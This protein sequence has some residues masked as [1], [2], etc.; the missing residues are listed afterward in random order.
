MMGRQEYTPLP[1][2]LSYAYDK[3]NLSDIVRKADNEKQMGY[4]FT[5]DAF[6]KRT[7]VYWSGKTDA[8]QLLQSTTYHPWL[9]VPST[10]TYGNGDTVG[11]YYNRAGLMTDRL[12]N[13]KRVAQYEYNAHNALGSESYYR[14]YANQYEKKIYTYD[15]AGRMSRLE[16]ST[17]YG[18]GN[19]VYDKNNNLTN[20]MSEVKDG[21]LKLAYMTKLTYNNMNALTSLQVQPE[22]GYE[23]GT[24]R[25]G[26][27]GLGRMNIKKVTLDSADNTLQ[28][29]YT[30]KAWTD[31]DGTG[32]RTLRP[33]TT[34][35]SGTLGNSS[36]NT[37]YFTVFLGDGNIKYQR[38]TENGA[39]RKTSFAYDDLGQLTRAQTNSEA[40][41]TY[42]YDG[43]GNL[44]SSSLDG[45]YTSS[46]SYDENFSDLLTGYTKTLSDGTVQSRAYTYTAANGNTFVNPT[47][48]QKSTNGAPTDTLQLSWR[49]GRVLSS[50]HQ[51]A[52]QIRYEYNGDGLRTYREGTDGSRWYYYY[53]GSQ[54]EYVKLT[55]SSGNVTGV[56]RYIYNS[57]GQ[58]EY[59]MYIKSSSIANP[60][61]YDLYYILRDNLG[62]ITKLIKTRKAT[63]SSVTATLEIAAEYTYDPY[64]TVLNI[65][66]VNGD[67][68]A[69]LNQLMY[70]DYIY[71]SDTGWYYLQSRYYDPEVGRFINGD[72][73]V[74]DDILG[75]NSFA[76][77]GNNPINRADSNGESWWIVA[78]AVVGAL[79]GGIT[80][81][82]SNVITGKKW[83]DG[84][85]GAAVGG[86]VY[87]IVLATTGNVWAAGFA[88]AAAESWTNEALSYIPG[89]AQING[90]TVTKKLTKGNVINSAK[91]IIKDTAVN[92]TISA[93][94]GKLAGYIV[95]TGKTWIKPQKFVSSFF[96]KYAVKSELQTVTQSLGV[97]AA[98][99]AKQ[100]FIQ[101]SRLGQRPV[102]K[103]FPD[104]EIRAAG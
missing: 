95:P 44:T 31:T 84:L 70:K 41:Y 73:Q 28:T 100:V 18:V 6:G 12:Y 86:A 72:G 35:I 37:S 2:R 26:Y 30:Y 13:G 97:F 76:Y 22:G 60:K 53:N 90:Q 43:G 40:A 10:V 77:C 21:Q 69:S 89:V 67:A 61:T 71:D 94:T 55:D 4:H 20:Y 93:A 75:S 85:L 29:T 36:V 7:G 27:D 82:A 38:V 87:G 79:A 45:A 103:F 51:N 11:Y 57:S 92:G 102:I 1:T 83:Y 104:T 15:L 56:L 80:K 64:G 50:V 91:T 46:Y 65:R 3:G 19:I 33:S 5:Y 78:N 99:K 8:E 58:A 39:E 63:S 54:L 68:I 101:D 47:T 23:S 98:E 34:T 14:P 62:S 42:A 17:G 96:G 52:G 88:G 32:L 24:I 25:Y 59:V 49:E 74:N 66:N 48:I 81:V 16:E 9:G